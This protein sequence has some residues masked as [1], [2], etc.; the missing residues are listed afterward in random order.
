[1]VLGAEGEPKALFSGVVA[2][3][4]LSAGPEASGRDRC[5]DMER[6]WKDTEEGMQGDVKAIHSKRYTK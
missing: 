4:E 1:M 3:N 5:G 6:C 2:S